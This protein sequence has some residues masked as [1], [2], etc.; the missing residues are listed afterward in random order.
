MWELILADTNS[1]TWS[2][3]T[4]LTYMTISPF[5]KKKNTTSTLKN[6]L[7]L[8]DLYMYLMPFPSRNGGEK[9]NRIDAIRM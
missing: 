8:Q 3:G 1:A 4:I 5:F 9:S 7:R 2:S 6:G